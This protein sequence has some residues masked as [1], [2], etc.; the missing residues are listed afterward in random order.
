MSDKEDLFDF[1]L[2]LAAEHPH[3]PVTLTQ[4]EGGICV[5]LLGLELEPDDWFFLPV[6]VT[7]LA[8]QL[9]PKSI[10]CGYFEF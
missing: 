5:G 9:T 10:G 4:G 6:P 2:Q 7:Q 8:E 1:L 3:Q